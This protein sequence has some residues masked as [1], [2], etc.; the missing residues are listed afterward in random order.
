MFW[1]VFGIWFDISI[2][3]FK[4]EWILII[5]WYVNIFIWNLL[6]CLMNLVWFDFYKLNFKD[7]LVY[8]LGYC[9]IVKKYFNFI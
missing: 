5:K 4:N 8:D 7:I 3:I 9:L 1:E 2:L 6:F